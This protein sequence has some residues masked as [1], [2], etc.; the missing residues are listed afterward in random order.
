MPHEICDY[1]ALKTPHMFIAVRNLADRCI[2]NW[3]SFKAR[4]LASMSLAMCPSI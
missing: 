1:I 3:P 4:P 2:R